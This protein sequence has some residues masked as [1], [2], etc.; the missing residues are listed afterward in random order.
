MLPLMNPHLT[1]LRTQTEVPMAETETVSN[2]QGTKR[3]KPVGSSSARSAIKLRRFAPVTLGANG[4]PIVLANIKYSV[5]VAALCEY[6]A[7]VEAA[8]T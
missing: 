6:A 7:F 1:A 4:R 8:V 5:D 2:Q 3:K